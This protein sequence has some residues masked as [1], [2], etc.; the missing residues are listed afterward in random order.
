MSRLA[1]DTGNPTVVY[2]PRFLQ[3]NTAFSKAYII[4]SNSKL[5]NTKG[6]GCGLFI[7][8][9]FFDFLSRIDTDKPLEWI[10]RGDELYDCFMWKSNR[11]GKRYCH[12]GFSLTQTANNI[13]YNDSW[14]T[15]VYMA[16]TYFPFDEPVDEFSINIL[17]FK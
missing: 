8:Y 10:K 1:T 7:D 6:L 16:N 15:S 4:E 13:I 14:Q 12:L 9:S 5:Y 11:D 17:S 2:S 3:L